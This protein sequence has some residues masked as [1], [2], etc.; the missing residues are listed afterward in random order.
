[1]S[2]ENQDDPVIGDHTLIQRRILDGVRQC[3]SDAAAGVF[4][5]LGSRMRDD[6]AIRFEFEAESTAK[7]VAQLPNCHPLPSGDEGF[8]ARL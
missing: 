5:G 6:N 1:M 4:K 8:A 3:V 2:F 7:S